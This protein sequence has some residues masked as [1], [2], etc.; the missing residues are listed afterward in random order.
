MGLVTDYTVGISYT[1][2]M[3]G[4]LNGVYKASASLTFIF[5]CSEISINPVS[6]MAASYT[7]TMDGSVVYLS[8]PTYSFDPQCG[9]SVA[10]YTYTVDVTGWLY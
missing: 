8:L 4:Y 2:A 10:T 5:M 9:S 3:D 6:S 7:Y 1:T